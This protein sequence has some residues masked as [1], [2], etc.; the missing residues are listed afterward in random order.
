LTVLA[1]SLLYFSSVFQLY[2]ATP[3]HSGLGDWIDPYFINYLLEHW[4]RSFLSFTDPAS[5][6]MYFPARGTLGY[7]HGLIL[8]AP[9]YAAARLFLH[10][11]QAYT[12]SLFLVM[13]AGCLCLYVLLR[14]FLRLGFFEALILTIFFV[15]SRN[16]LQASIA[17]WSQRASVFLLPII[18]LIVLTT[19]RMPSGRPRRILAWVSGLLPPLFFIQD[20][21]TAQFTLIISIM[22]LAGG[23]WLSRAQVV[24]VLSARWNTARSVF[25]QLEPAGPM[26]RQPSSWWIVLA[27]L[28]LVA[29]IAIEVHPVP[30]TII[31]GWRVSADRSDRALWLAVL[32]GGWYVVRR[33]QLV[34]RASEGWRQA[35]DQVAAA[36]WRLRQHPDLWSGAFGLS[37]GS[38]LFLWIYLGAY[39][40]HPTFAEDMLTHALATLD[41]SG[42]SG[43]IGFLRTLVPYDSAR[44]FALVFVVALLAWVP[45]FRVD[46]TSRVGGLWFLI[47]SALIVAAPV[48][49]GDFSLWMTFFRWLPGTSVIRD[50]KRIVEVYELAVVLVAGLFLFR[51][52]RTSL[53]RRAMPIALLVLAVTDWSRVVFTYERPNST[54]RQ[55]VEAPLVIE[56]DNAH[57]ATLVL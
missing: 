2:S 50:P 19:L 12:V 56:E 44:S 45:W 36:D 54:Y 51:L 9:F 39:R 42:A 55:M 32:A 53:F 29:A 30:R 16:V 57:S 48:R 4:Y 13:E 38:L 43:A 23:L 11:F 34:A 40:E 33:W 26:S 25:E 47:V 52:P 41:A 28:S 24:A 20:F 18:L 5:P 35:R 46:R 7:S 31:Y 15:S 17:V 27:I 14:K 21:Y 10:P 1:L 3:L 8:Y 6:P 49:L 22:I 37:M